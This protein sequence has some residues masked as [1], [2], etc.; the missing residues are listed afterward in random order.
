M[1]GACGVWGSP[2]IGASHYAPEAPVPPPLSIC[3]WVLKAVS[4]RVGVWDSLDGWD[5]GGHCGS[6]VERE[7]EAID[8]CGSVGSTMESL[9]LED[10]GGV[11]GNDST[12]QVLGEANGLMLGLGLGHSRKDKACENLK[13]KNSMK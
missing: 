11:D 5:N 9:L 1:R 4:E 13:F 8:S 3:V 2:I 12:V 7:L 6:N 10:T